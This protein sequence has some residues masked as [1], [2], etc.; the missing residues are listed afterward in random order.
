MLLSY[1]D[2]SMRMMIEIYGWKMIIKGQVKPNT[3]MYYMR[4]N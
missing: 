3:N 2:E 4:N 1:D